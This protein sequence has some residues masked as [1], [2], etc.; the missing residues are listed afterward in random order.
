M[1]FHPRVYDDVV[2]HVIVKGG[3]FQFICH[4][5]TNN[6]I[7]FCE[8]RQGWYKFIEMYKTQMTHVNFM[9]KV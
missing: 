8:L 9:K 4:G 6:G 2:M 1:S 5:C 7:L 3:A